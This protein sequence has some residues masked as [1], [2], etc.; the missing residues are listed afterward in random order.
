MPLFVGQGRASTVICLDI[1]KAFNAVPHRILAGKL[2][3]YELD[4]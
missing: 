4:G 3:R 1:S 2:V